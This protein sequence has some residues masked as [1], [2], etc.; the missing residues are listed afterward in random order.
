MESMMQSFRFFEHRVIL[1]DQR[2]TRQRT[3]S[4]VEEQAQETEE[5]PDFKDAKNIVVK[6]GSGDD[7]QIDIHEVPD[8]DQDCNGHDEFHV[9]L[10][11]PSDQ[12]V[13]WNGE[14]HKE[15]DDE[16]PLVACEES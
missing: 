3:Q 8:E 10:G 7:K 6:H 1:R 2:R 5:Q 15:H 11:V 9:P 4:A 13:E 14:V 12:D 16:G